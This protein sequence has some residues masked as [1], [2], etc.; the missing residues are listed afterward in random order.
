MIEL[1][2]IHTIIIMFGLLVLVMATGV[3]VV[4]AMGGLGVVLLL[5]TQGPSALTSI[6]VANAYLATQ[7]YSMIA[8]PLFV[9]MSLVLRSSGIIDDLFYAMRMWLAPIPG[10]LA[11]A[12]VGV[13]VFI[14]AMSGITAT[15][16]LVLGITAVPMMLKF[17]YSKQMTLGPIVAG[18]ALAELIPPSSAFIVYGSIAEVSVGQLF[19][20][21]VIPGLVLAGLFAAYI[22]VRCGLNPK[23]GPPVPREERIGWGAKFLTFRHLILP[24]FVIAT[25]LGSIFFGIAS[26]TEAAAMGAAG[27]LVAAAIKRRLTFSLIK[28]TV[29]EC[30]K[31][32]AIVIW[33]MIGAYTFKSVFVLGGGP[34]IVNDWIASLQ[35]SPIGV[36][37]A[38]QGVFVILGCFVQELV[39]MLLTV[40]VFV[41]L[42]EAL[43]FSKVWFGVLL[44]TS[45]QT[46]SCTPPFGYGLFYMRSVAPKDV[47]M[48]DIIMSVLPFVG[49]QLV[50]VALVLAFPQLALWLPSIMVK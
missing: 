22:L 49:I 4:F 17:G 34:F 30:G 41:P 11:V 27:A 10:G 32:T 2:G 1:T 33:I 24:L 3:P 18:A 50:A 23:L 37:I 42:A 19:M 39:V 9:F 6:V 20:G 47:S 25:C 44:E 8:V 7:W 46:A 31:V 5:L 13:C 29:I 16:V 35:I 38:M 45:L 14:A 15:A 28:E 36:I 43:G 21:G 12:V 26:P 40:P 48:Q